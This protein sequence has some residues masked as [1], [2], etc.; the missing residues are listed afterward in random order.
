MTYET[1]AVAPTAGERDVVLV[2]LEHASWPNA[3]RYA[4]EVA[5]VVISGD[6]TYLAIGADTDAGPTDDTGVDERSITIPDP[7]LI[8]W[9]RLEK[10]SRN[11]SVLPVTVTISVYL[12]TDL[13]TPAI[14]PA[15]LR[16]TSPS[17]DGRMVTFSA[18][19]ADVVN[20][21]APTRKFTWAN[22]PGLRR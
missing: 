10:L 22:S 15:V 17:R 7:D 18:S 21:D 20:R 19:S 5:D 4:D 16:M 12:S 1:H 3:L 2:K 14:E 11:G 6:G 8:L 13:T 9:R